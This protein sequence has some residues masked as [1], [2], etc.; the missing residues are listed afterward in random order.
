VPRRPPAE[1]VALAAVLMAVAA[2]EIGLSAEPSDVS[3]PALVAVALVVT[4][5]LAWR[6]QAPFAS[7]LIVLATLTAV[8]AFWRTSGLWIGLVG[9]VAM[10]SV[11]A[12]TTRV[13]ATVAGV[14]WL[15]GGALS[16][17]HED[18]HGFWDLLGNFVFLGLF[19]VGA[20]WAAGRMQRRRELRAAALEG[21]AQEAVLEER[22][23]LARELHDVVG[24]GLG[25]IAV[26]AG[27]E[28]A[29]LADAPDSTR[30]T[31]MTIE[32]TARDALG[33][34]RRLLDLMRQG[35]E[36]MALAP[37]PS[38][39]HLPALIEN[40]RA[41][42][43][44]VEVHTEGEPH[45]LSPG[46]DVSAY[47]IVQEALTNALKHA[48]PARA[49]VALRYGAADLELEITDDGAGAR[50]NRAGN[51]HGLVGMRERVALHR[52]SLRTGARPG[53]G[54]AVSVRLPYELRS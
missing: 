54:Y 52:G 8:S 37:Q 42:G 1:D 50:D 32:R 27:A 22:Q 43:L 51:G 20:P 46:V 44:P 15:V 16:I 7:A 26:Q 14:L 36:S 28:R 48:G 47:R 53:G 34:M 30:E 19:F 33:E 49:R 38:L 13:P 31:L 6:R 11:A 21:R 41:A 3:R 39:D 4:T 12:H 23:R 9:L 25:V 29:T 40:V 18:N 17:A 45:A 24:H 5:A 2:A 10:Y 35:D